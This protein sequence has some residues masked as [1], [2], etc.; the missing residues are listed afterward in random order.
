ML[1]CSKSCSGTEVNGG[2]VPIQREK[3]DSSLKYVA[4]LVFNATRSGEFC[5][6]VVEIAI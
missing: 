2:D 5:R 1:H 4:F 3:V 6:K